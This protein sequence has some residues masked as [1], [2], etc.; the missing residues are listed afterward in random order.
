MTSRLHAHGLQGKYALDPDLT[1]LGKYI[2]GG[3]TFGA[4]GG[5]RALMS[6]CDPRR[7]ESISHSGTFNN[8]TLTL[9][10]GAVGLSKIYTPQVAE[11]HNKLGDDFRQR[12]QAVA[13]GT[14]MVATGVG[15]VLTVHFMRNGIEPACEADIEAQN[16]PELKK[17]FWFWCLRAGYWIT[18]RG[19][20][21]IILGTTQEELSQFAETVRLFHEEYAH[22]LEVGPE[23]SV[24]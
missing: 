5:K 20:L 14:K 8:N 13:R 22:L 17:L 11:Q 18:E 21:S 9:S 23:T 7:P 24:L 10:C 15:A 12:L 1:T 16:V 3:M 4:F 2:G 19:M 6:V